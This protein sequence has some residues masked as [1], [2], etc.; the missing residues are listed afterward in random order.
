MGHAGDGI[1]FALSPNLELVASIGGDQTIK[2]W[3]VSSGRLLRNL[4]AQ[5]ARISDDLA[6]TPDGLSVISAGDRIRI[7]K[8]EDGQLKRE[9]GSVDAGNNFSLQNYVRAIAVSPDGQHVLAGYRDHGVR[10]WNISTGMLTRTF[11]GMREEVGAVKFSPDGKFVVAASRIGF[12]DSDVSMWDVGS[13][14]LVRR[15][16]PQERLVA[17]RWFALT[18]HRIWKARHLARQQSVHCHRDRN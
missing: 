18:V 3:E 15:F 8:L 11:D 1:S 7:W 16:H 12:Q 6:F 13:G 4:R 2:L 14:E 5:D 10:L 9:I 17:S